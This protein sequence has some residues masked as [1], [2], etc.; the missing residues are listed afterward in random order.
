MRILLS[1]KVQNL[2]TT[3]HNW[4]TCRTSFVI[5]NIIW[6]C[7]YFEFFFYVLVKILSRLVHR[8]NQK[9]CF[10][11][12]IWILVLFLRFW[13]IFFV[14]HV[15]IFFCWG[16]EWGRIWRGFSNFFLNLSRLH[17]I[18]IKIM[19]FFQIFLRLWLI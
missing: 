9:F 13:H 5:Y 15:D 10:L 18:S 14:G 1:W 19:F 12:F 6:I 8:R 11:H 4:R 7:I 3:A 17:H 2:L 16:P